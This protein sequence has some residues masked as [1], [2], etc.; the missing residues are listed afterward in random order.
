MDGMNFYFD[1]VTVLCGAYCLFTAI[2]LRIVGHLFPNQLLIPGD[3]RPEDC[4]DEDAYISYIWIRLL[5]AGAVC[6]ISGVIALVENSW[7]IITDLLPG[8]PDAGRY[9]ALVSVGVSI[10]AVVWVIAC[11]LKAKKLFWI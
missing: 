8:H 11:W 1:L 6:L 3:S 10:V 7:K 9:I 4:I 2:K 5:I